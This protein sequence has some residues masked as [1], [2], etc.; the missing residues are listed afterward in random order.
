MADAESRRGSSGNQSYPE[1]AGDGAN[2][3]QSKSEPRYGVRLTAAER[4]ELRRSQGIDP[5]GQRPVP[6][7]AAQSPS[8]P[9]FPRRGGAQAGKSAP[10]TDGGSERNPYA[11]G[12]FSHPDSSAQSGHGGAYVGADRGYDAAGMGAQ[13]QLRLPSQKGPW[14]LIVLSAVL[15]IVVPLGVIGYETISLMS[16]QPE[17][18]TA[19]G[20]RQVSAGESFPVRSGEKVW[21][22]IQGV[23]DSAT[24]MLHTSSA[25]SSSEGLSGNT[26]GAQMQQ[27]FVSFPKVDATEASIS[28]GE[29]QPSALFV[30]T[31]DIEEWSFQTV[32]V[33]QIAL[34]VGF[35][36]LVSL[37]V[38][39]VWLVRVRRRRK[40]MMT[41]R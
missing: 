33:L 4:D 8:G 31:G 34:L 10:V 29:V 7:A 32:Q 41:P 1:Q 25:G 28:C 22:V 15:M 13:S 21:A 20:L 36:C 11:P 17:G 39:I 26:I 27:A 37:I 2:T 30:G 35:V 9:R 24:C 38:G 3:Q 18:S 5:V 14:W 23:D 12:N 40:R 16:A 19:G 6:G